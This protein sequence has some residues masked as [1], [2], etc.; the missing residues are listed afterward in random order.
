MRGQRSDVG[1][2]IQKRKGPHNMNMK[3]ILVS[4]ILW[5]LA[6]LVSAVRGSEGSISVSQTAV[7]GP[8]TRGV[9]TSLPISYFFIQAKDTNGEK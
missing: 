3:G 2:E 8:G 5:A 1:R 6:L 4:Y 9:T 7:Y